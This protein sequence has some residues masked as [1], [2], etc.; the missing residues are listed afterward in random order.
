[1]TN[2]VVKLFLRLGADPD[3]RSEASEAH[4]P[5]LPNVFQLTRFGA[6]SLCARAKRRHFTTH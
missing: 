5:D 2:A 3:A 1:M 6:L 4:R